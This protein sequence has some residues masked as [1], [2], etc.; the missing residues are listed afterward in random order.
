MDG[1]NRIISF[2]LGLI[3]VIVSIAVI[4]GKLNLQNRIRPFITR[5]TTQKPTPTKMASTSPT[6]KPTQTPTPI[7]T[8]LENVKPA[9]IKKPGVIPETGTP[10]AIIPLLLAIL[11][12]GFFVKSRA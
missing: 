7:R 5:Q 1:V 4:T 12:G 3:V 9:G 10:T 11:I 8:L 2:I 6:H